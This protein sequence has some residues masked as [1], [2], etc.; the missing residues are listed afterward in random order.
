MLMRQQKMRPSALTRPEVETKVPSI[1]HG[2]ENS[3][4]QPRERTRKAAIGRGHREE[5]N[6]L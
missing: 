6:H 2:I 1:P 4:Y 3:A 5:K